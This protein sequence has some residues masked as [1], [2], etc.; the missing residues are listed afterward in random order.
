VVL[1]ALRKISG[2]V[3]LDELL[4][5]V[6]WDC[7]VRA[8]LATA[9]GDISPQGREVSVFSDGQQPALHLPPRLQQGCGSGDIDHA[10]S[11]IGI[12]RAAG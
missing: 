2:A 9:L 5:G 3:G 4:V 6:E 8:D 12:P 1:K 7:R 10:M 11:E